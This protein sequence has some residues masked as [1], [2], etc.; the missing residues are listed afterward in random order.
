M[1]EPYD[2]EYEVQ[3]NTGII[4]ENIN[5]NVQE[6]LQE[7]LQGNIHGNLHGNLHKNMKLKMNSQQTPG[8][9]SEPYPPLPNNKINKI[10]LIKENRIQHKTSK[11]ETL[12]GAFGLHDGQFDIPKNQVIFWQ[13]WVRY[14]HYTMEK[15]I[16]KPRL[17]FQ[18]NR[19]YNQRIPISKRFNKD[20]THTCKVKML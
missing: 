12:G 11:L 15:K 4:H 3:S 1:T 10:K 6:N 20:K 17:F 7:N 5:G 9:L 19:F 13:G 16:T 2:K 18:N 8:Y 14:Y